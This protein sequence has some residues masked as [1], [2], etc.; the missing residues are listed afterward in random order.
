MIISWNINTIWKKYEPSSHL[1]KSDRNDDKHPILTRLTT[2][3]FIEGFIFSSLFTNFS[4][5]RTFYI[6]LLTQFSPRWTNSCSVVPLAS[7]GE[8][9]HN[10]CA[11][12]VLGLLMP[13]QSLSEVCSQLMNLLDSFLLAFELRKI[14]FLFFLYI[15]FFSFQPYSEKQKLRIVTFKLQPHLCK[16]ELVSASH[17]IAKL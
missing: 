14:T 17:D 5:I 13:R 1:C 8:G 12:K 2:I 6:A 11:W 7:D 4:I 15:L 3:I 9:K 10:F 16:Q